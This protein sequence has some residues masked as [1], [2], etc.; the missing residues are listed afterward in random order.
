MLQ[1]TLGCKLLEL[2]LK[3]SNAFRRQ[4]ASFTTTVLHMNC[5]LKQQHVQTIV[6]HRSEIVNYAL[7]ASHVRVPHYK[8]LFAARVMNITAGSSIR[9]SL[10]HKR[11]T[12]N[13]VIPRDNKSMAL[14]GSML[15]NGL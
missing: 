15:S 4:H 11:N 3:A 6:F 5:Q 10:N 7:S 1:T 2:M 13:N 12:N 9:E 14:R 8:W